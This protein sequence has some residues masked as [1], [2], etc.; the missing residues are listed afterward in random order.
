MIERIGQLFITGFEGEFPPDDFL[1]FYV[2]EN[3][4][5]IILFEEQCTPNSR[6]EEIIRKINSVSRGRVSFFAVDQEGGR[7]CRL[8]GAPAEYLS[9]R[10]YGEK[11]DTELFEEHFTRSAYYLNS[12]GIN[13]LLAPVADLALNPQNTCLEGRTFGRSASHVIPFIEKAVKICNKVGLLSC[14]K[15]FPGLGAATNDPHIEMAVAD[16]DLQT[17]LNREA[18]TFKAGIDAGTDMVM[19]THMILS[20]IDDNP[21]TI[22]NVIVEQF[23]RKRLEFDGIV[24]TDDLLMKGIR[25]LGGYGEKSMAAFKAGHDL[26]LFGENYKA[27]MEAVKYFKEEYRRGMVDDKKL[28][29]SLNRISGIKSKIALPVT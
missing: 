25:Q 14:L 1:E 18:L 28:Q 4:G 17:F 8:R 24:I 29:S 2:S 27:T 23:L 12:L 6:A 7:V 10:E 19:T 22:S 15:H 9:A 20:Q 3:I 21:A 16:F 5:G 11:G 13:L 26:L